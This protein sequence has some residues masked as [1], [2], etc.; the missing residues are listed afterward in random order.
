MHKQYS[1]VEFYPTKKTGIE[2]LGPGTK[3]TYIPEVHAMPSME[4]AV[5][6]YAAARNPYA[7]SCVTH[8]SQ[9]KVSNYPNTASTV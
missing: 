7:T 6:S 5:V 9:Q 1:L 2:S 4:R 8:I 3:S